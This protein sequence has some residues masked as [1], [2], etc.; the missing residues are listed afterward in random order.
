VKRLVLLVPVLPFLFGANDGCTAEN[1]AEEVW[2]EVTL[3]NGTEATNGEAL[4]ILKNDETSTD[5]TL[6][7]PGESRVVEEYLPRG[8]RA[9]RGYAVQR[10]A[11]ALEVGNGACE[12]DQPDSIQLPR[13]DLLVEVVPNG[14]G[15]TYNVICYNWDEQ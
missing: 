13:E 11:S 8:E 7:Q 6:L 4:H 14:N 5:E 1:E 9:W 15:E 10:G 2:H 12:W 3:R